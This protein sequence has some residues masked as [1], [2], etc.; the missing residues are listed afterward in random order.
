MTCPSE[1]SGW[2]I[3]L[4]FCF[5]DIVAVCDEGLSLTVPLFFVWIVR[6]QR[7][8]VSPLH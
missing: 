6:R 2:S 1:L 7:R 3:S 8:H 5:D 4:K